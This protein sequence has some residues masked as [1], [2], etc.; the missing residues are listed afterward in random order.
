MK[1]E[2]VKTVK[3]KVIVDMSPEQYLDGRSDHNKIPL[4][5]N[6]VIIEEEYVDSIDPVSN[7][8]WVEL[9]QYFTEKGKKK[10]D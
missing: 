1:V 7:E 5:G 8:D 4:Y 10:N 3:E 6:P 2:I 9:Y